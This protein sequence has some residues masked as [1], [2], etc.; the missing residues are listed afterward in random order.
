MDESRL[1][2]VGDLPGFAP[3]IARLVSMMNYARW[4]TLRAADGLTASQLDY[5]HDA[6]SNSVGALLKH[7]AAVEV[8][9]QAATFESRG[10]SAAEQRE[11][12]AALDLGEQARREIRGR[13]LP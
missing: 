1:F 9:Y 4:T 2:L 11:W 10:L 3:Q 5:L 6:G 12:G 13:E 7:I 8:S